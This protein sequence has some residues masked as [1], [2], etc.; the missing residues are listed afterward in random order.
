LRRPRQYQAAIASGKSTCRIR[1][2]APPNLTR[3]SRAVTR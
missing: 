3:A 1:M 2:T